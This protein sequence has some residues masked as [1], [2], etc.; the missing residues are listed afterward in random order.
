MTDKARKLIE[1][2]DVTKWNKKPIY[3]FVK[4]CRKVALVIQE[5]TGEFIISKKYPALCDVDKAK[6]NSLLCE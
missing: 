3:Y 4:G 2:G 1:R 6:V 5:E